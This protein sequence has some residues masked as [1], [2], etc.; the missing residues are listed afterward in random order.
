MRPSSFHSPG[1]D[2]ETDA[3]IRRIL[4]RWGKTEP[5]KKR[6]PKE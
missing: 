4:R 1:M 6:K 5:S 3:V 2:K